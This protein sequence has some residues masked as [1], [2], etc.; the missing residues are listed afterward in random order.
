MKKKYSIL[1]ALVLLFASASPAFAAVVRDETVYVSLEADGSVKT[2]EV[3]NRL[4][5]SDSSAYFTDYGKY[6]LR[7]VDGAEPEQT[8]RTPWKMDV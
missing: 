6:D 4:S 5:G 7:F 1:L 2:V 3:V 8:G